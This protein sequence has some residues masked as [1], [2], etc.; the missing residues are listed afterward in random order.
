MG[1]ENILPGKGV[2]GLYLANVEPVMLRE[3]CGT[4]GPCGRIFWVW[5]RL[6]MPDTCGGGLVISKGAW[7]LK[8]DEG[9][10]GGHVLWLLWLCIGE[11][12]GC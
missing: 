1:M 4:A 10:S 11:G 12:L 3:G 7:V 9:G 6:F 8:G 5:L 2:G